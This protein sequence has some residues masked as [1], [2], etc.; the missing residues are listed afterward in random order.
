MQE[1]SGSEHV[2]MDMASPLGDGSRVAVE[3]ELATYDSVFTGKVTDQFTAVGDAVAREFK[4]L[5]GTE[6]SWLKAAHG[7]ID[8][9]AEN[10]YEVLKTG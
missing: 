3:G 7:V 1:P 4:F 10:G 8:K 5:N 9:L 6:E 2:E